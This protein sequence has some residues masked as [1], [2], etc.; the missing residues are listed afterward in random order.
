MGLT[1]LAI[2]RPVFILMLMVGAILMGT[3]SYR[4]MRLEQNPDVQVGVITATTVYP[5]A[6]PEEVNNLVSK[7]IEEAVSGLSGL[8]T[9]TSTSQEGVSTVVAEFEIG[10]DMNQALNDFRSKVDPVA[11]V[12]PTGALKP[13]ISK[14]DFGADPV[15]VMALRSDSMDNQQLRDLADQK[16]KDR[17]ARIPGV[18][19]VDVSGGDVREIRVEVKRD[20]LVAYGLG[21]V[22]VQ[23]AILSATLNVP[24]GRVVTG[25]QEFNVRVLGEFKT[26]EDVRNTV[27][28]IRDQRTQFGK[29]KLVRLVEVATVTDGT[30]ERRSYSRLNGSDAVVVSIQKAKEGS[31]VQIAKA[32]IELQKGLAKEFGIEMV[33]TRNEADR[34]TESLADLNFALMFGVLLVTLIVFVFLHDI[35]GT[36]IVGI[37]IPVAIFG[38]FIVLRALGFTINTMSMLALSLAIGVLVDDAIVVLENIYRHLKM[39][40]DPVSAAINGRA[41]IG[42]AAIAITLAD[43]VIFIPIAFMGGVLGQ[44]FRPLGIAFAAATLLSLFVSFTVT[45]MLASRWYRQGEDI[46]HPKGRFGQWFERK[47]KG[48]ENHYRRALEW[49]L[50]H[51]WFVFITGFVVLL[52]VF[53]AI[54]GAGGYKGTLGKVITGEFPMS[55]LAGALLLG[56]VVFGTQF[57]GSVV[58]ARVRKRMWLI[59]TAALIVVLLALP[60]SQ[61][62]VAP[63]VKVLLAIVAYWPLVGLVA[64]VANV[65]MR[66]AQSRRLLQALAFGLVFPLA[67]LAGFEFGSWKDESSFKFGFFPSSDGGQV[68]VSAQLAPGASLSETLRVVERIERILAKHP[69]SRS[70]RSAGGGGGGGGFGGGSSLGSNFGQVNATLNDRAAMADSLLFWKKHAESLRTRSDKSIAADIQ[71]LVKRIPGADLTITAASAVGFG[72]PIQMSFASEDRELLVRTVNSIRLKLDQGAIPGVISPD[73]SSKPGKPEIRAVPDRARLADAGL[74][75]ADVANSM[76]MLYEGNNDAKFRTEGKEHDIRVMMDVGDRNNLA[77]VDGVPLTFVQGNPVFLSQVAN[78]ERGTGLDQIQRR[79]REEE[80]RLSAELLPNFAAGSVQGEIDKWLAD[81]KLVPERVHI[82]PLGQA[83]LQAREGIFLF[84]ALGIGLVLVYMLLAS[85]FD[86]LLYPFIIQLAQPQAMVGAIL[87]IV[88]FDK[89]LNIVGFIGIIT[90]VGLVGKNAILLVDYTNTLRGRGKDRHDALVEAGPT[91]L[92][93]ILMTTL[94]LILAMLPVA[95]AIGRGSEFRETIGITIIGGIL[96]STMLTLLVIP[97]SYTIFDDLAQK[98]GKRRLNSPPAALPE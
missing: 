55:L 31:A 44:F 30:A 75:T 69:S 43:V 57:W 15:L 18:A 33:N 97:C 63:P 88:L 70:A 21:I 77:L 85:L 16:L 3:L 6:G 2:T 36:I 66:R 22:D 86:N 76:R 79:N 24:S 45:P 72:P 42:L 84:T 9:V 61:L 94:A 14:L 20:K 34:I 35:R 1:R 46:E 53:V 68:S 60:A 95:L 92:R 5:G 40:E 17:F 37:A 25:D 91:R 19:S 8:R 65:T 12:L 48:L 82:K 49:S 13:T 26:V 74:S 90:L 4:G 41:E 71:Q 62:P 52:S 67:A 81:E 11:G 89:A 50:N 98:I 39:G 59:G 93:P 78:L 56:L 27:L 87:A 51:R 80:V 38:T 23:R 83:E 54:A 10:T 28:Q 73:I 29:P 58:S 47:F 7:R 32:A 64:F 96:L